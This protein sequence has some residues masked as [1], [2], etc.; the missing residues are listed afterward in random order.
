M[1]WVREASLELSAG[2]NVANASLNVQRGRRRSRGNEFA[3][4]CSFVE[5]RL[6][7]KEGAIRHVLYA[8]GRERGRRIHFVFVWK[9]NSRRGG[10]QRWKFVSLSISSWNSSPLEPLPRD[11]LHIIAIG[12]RETRF[13]AW[14]AKLP[15]S[16]K[17]VTRNKMKPIDYYILGAQFTQ[18]GKSELL[19]YKKE[20]VNMT[21]SGARRARK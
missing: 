18:T 5:E 21:L 17:S 7:R 19:R 14:P 9:K 1:V 2:C 12:D 11:F 16:K 4:E 20:T 6:T 13:K 10:N 3:P 15:R 8:I